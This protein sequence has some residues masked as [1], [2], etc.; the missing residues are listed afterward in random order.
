M[1]NKIYEVEQIDGKII[2]VDSDAYNSGLARVVRRFINIGNDS[3]GSYY[4]EES[5]AYQ[6]LSNVLKFDII[7]EKNGITYFR[8][9]EKVSYT[10]F[11]SLSERRIIINNI[12]DYDEN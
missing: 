4:S 3:E 7:S 8:I 2:Y 1:T 5:I 6:D 9:D 11:Y 10:S 12:G